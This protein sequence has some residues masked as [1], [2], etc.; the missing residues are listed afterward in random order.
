MLYVLALLPVLVLVVF[1][2][3]RSVKEAAVAGL[4]VATGLFFYWGASAKHYLAVVGVSTLS[5]LSIIMIVLGALFLYNLMRG[6]GLV[7]EI[8]QSLKKVHPEKEIR[9]FLLA[10]CL[11]A[12]F[13]GVAG[14]G[15]PGAIVPLLLMAMGYNGLVSVSIVLLFDG[16]FAMFGAVGT[17]LITGLQMPLHLLPDQVQRI[18]F[19]AAVLGVVVQGILLLFVFRLLAKAGAPVQYKGKILVLYL[20]FAIPFCVFAWVATDLATVLASITMLVLSVF[21]LK[22]KN[23]RLDLRPWLPYAVLA[24]LLVLPKIWTPLRDFLQWE[25]SFPDF[26]ETGIY[27]SIKPLFSPLIP[28]VLVGLGV[29]YFRKSPSFYLKEVTQKALNI[30]LVLLPA[31]MIAQLMIYSGVEQPSMVWHI[32]SLMGRLQEAYVVFAPILGL[33]GAFIT[34]STTVSNLVFGA[35]Q[36]E[37]AQLLGIDSAV[38]LALQLMGA[39]LGNAICLF[40]IVAA[41]SIANIQDYK[42]ILALNLTPALIGA[43]LAGGIGW[44]LLLYSS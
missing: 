1:S 19:L 10:F 6:T 21:Y 12:F 24:G 44:L 26:W 37:T 31:I 29:A 39:G 13:E 18:G 40:N 22:D 32:S 25:L 14:F 5:T 2:L 42:K 41:A 28:F 9:F 15:T 36:L 17:P 3:L 38:I 30:A 4:V 11:T 33:L 43:F 16:L 34:G 20:F 35:S 8:S 27:S 7:Q 23:A